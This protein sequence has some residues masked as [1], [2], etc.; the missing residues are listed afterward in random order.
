MPVVAHHKHFRGTMLQSSLVE[1]E[2]SAVEPTGTR[3]F[4][5]MEAKPNVF[6]LA[7]LGVVLAPAQ[8]DDVCY[9][10]FS[11]PFS[12]GPGRDGATER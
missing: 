10:E 2:G 12:V 8:V 1:L 5:V 3:L 9:P 11:K 7:D 4:I 6:E